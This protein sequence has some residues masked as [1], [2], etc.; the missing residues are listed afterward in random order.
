M[1]IEDLRKRSDKLDIVEAE[2]ADIKEKLEDERKTV[3]RLK[4]DLDNTVRWWNVD[5]NI[6]S[7]TKY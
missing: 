1:E 7:I 3:K 4:R 2:L 5:N 6:K